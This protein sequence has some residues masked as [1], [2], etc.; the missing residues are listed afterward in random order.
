MFDACYYDS[1]ISALYQPFANVNNNGRMSGTG[2]SFGTANVTMKKFRIAQK[3]PLDPKSGYEM[4]SGS[5]P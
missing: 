3:D 2:G 4:V 5:C 1:S